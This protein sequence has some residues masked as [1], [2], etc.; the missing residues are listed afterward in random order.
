MW[1][2]SQNQLA[3]GREAQDNLNYHPRQQFPATGFTLSTLAITYTK[4]IHFCCMR[5][6]FDTLV[7]TRRNEKVAPLWPKSYGFESW[8]QPLGKARIRLRLYTFPWP[9]QSGEP[10]LPPWPLC[11]ARVRMCKID[12]PPTLAQRGAFLAWVALFLGMLLIHT[13]RINGGFSGTTKYTSLILKQPHL[14]E[15][16]H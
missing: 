1:G 3:I 4:Y 2:T 13:L 8:K 7:V 6:A 15:I 12:V 9:L 14:E 10:Y 11:K 16:N 5:H